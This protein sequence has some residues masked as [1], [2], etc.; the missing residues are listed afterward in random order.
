MYMRISW[1]RVNPGQWEEYERAFLQALADAGP[2]DGLV[3]R[4]VSRDLDDP[5]TGYSVS[6][7]ETAEAMEAYERGVSPNAIVPK[8]KE[9]FTGAFVTNKL[10]VVFD[11]RYDQAGTTPGAS[12]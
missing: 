11:E 2:I 1:G 7:W 4:T 6:V 9:F 8:I 12:T 10:E 3:G 5:D